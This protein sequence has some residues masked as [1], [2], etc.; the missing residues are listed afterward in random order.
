MTIYACWVCH[1]PQKPCLW[2]WHCSMATPISHRM[3]FKRLM[4]IIVYYYVWHQMH[5]V[6]KCMHVRLFHVYIF[7]SILRDK[8]PFSLNAIKNM[9]SGPPIAFHMPHFLFQISNECAHCYLLCC[10]FS[11]TPLFSVSLRIRE[12]KNILMWEWQEIRS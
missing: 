10:S 1:R 5:D 3:T 6:R 2:T 7:M 8:N 9:K 11:F 12:E 4:I